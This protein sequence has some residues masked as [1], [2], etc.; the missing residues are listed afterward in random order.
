MSANLQRFFRWLW[1]HIDPVIA[2][3]VAL[4]CSILGLFS[5][6]KLDVLIPAILSTLTLIAFTLI[7]ERSGR[8]SLREKIDSVAGKIEHHVADTVFAN[9]TSETSVLQNA[10]AEVWLVQETGAL[11][12]ETN[13]N[14]LVSMLNQGRRVRMLLTS[15]M[16][17]TARLTAFRNA[18]LEQQGIAQRAAM[19]QHHITD[20]VK[21]A[22][23]HTDKLEVR[24]AAHVTDVTCAIADPAHADASRRNAVVRLAG[25]QVPYDEKL[26]MH[27]D[28]RTS[29]RVF[30]HYADQARRMFEHA[31]KVVLLTGAPS[32]GKTSMF[33]R[34]VE[35]IE[36]KSDV[37]YILAPS[38]LEGGARRGFEFITSKS[39]RPTKFAERQDGGEYKVAA[40]VWADSLLELDEALGGH[41]I[42]ILDEIGSIQ[43]RDS[44]FS[45]FINK[46]LADH[47]A[48]MFATIAL[49][50][51]RLPFLHQV[52]QHYR[53]T[54]LHLERGQNERS[55]EERLQRELQASLRLVRLLPPRLLKGESQ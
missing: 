15:N 9:R 46:V 2:L 5:V 26:D 13:K 44:R 29:P 40:N 22:K 3:I 16:D 45:G 21:Q 30:Q 7:R 12:I 23:N 17:V 43:L 14:H 19:T 4:A 33:K 28:G 49:D 37:Y 55:I 20:V 35:S 52:K 10:T 8:E 6:V 54:V 32:S 31:S 53:T 11:L 27:L 39:P 47:C 24:F 42:I 34:L 36:D 18:N 1:D 41:K 38:V 51:S 48:T 50:D 25:F